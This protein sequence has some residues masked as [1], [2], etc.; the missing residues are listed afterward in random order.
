MI[1]YN[2]V[3]KDHLQQR[4]VAAS[5]NPTQKTLSISHGMQLKDTSHGD[6]LLRVAAYVHSA[7]MVNGD[8]P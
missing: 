3:T 7:K 6:G 4:A 5:A 8:E 1:T 2:T